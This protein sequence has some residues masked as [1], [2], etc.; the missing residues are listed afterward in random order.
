MAL[1]SVLW[2]MLHTHIAGMLKYRGYDREST[3][4]N[5]LSWEGMIVF[6][7]FPFMVHSSLPG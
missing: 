6:N 2:R 4:D 7:V 3:G 1:I 5:K